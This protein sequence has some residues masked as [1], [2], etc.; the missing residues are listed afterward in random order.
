M[1]ELSG[2]HATLRLTQFLEENVGDTSG[3]LLATMNVLLRTNGPLVEEHLDEPLHALAHLVD[4][5]L[6]NEYSLQGFVRRVDAK[7][8]TGGIPPDPDDEYTHASVREVLTEL[9]ERIRGHLN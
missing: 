8:E 9:R 6:F 1:F 2:R 4:R 5:L 3:A 7:W